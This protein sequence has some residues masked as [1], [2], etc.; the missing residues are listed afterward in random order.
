MKSGNDTGFTAVGNSDFQLGDNVTNKTHLGHFTFYF[1]PVVHEPNHIMIARDVIFQGYYGGAGTKWFGSANNRHSHS[2][3]GGWENILASVQNAQRTRPSLL[4]ALAFHHESKN[5]YICDPMS[6]TG[7]FHS[8][9]ILNDLVDD[10]DGYHY[11]SA[12][13][14]SKMLGKEF[15]SLDD[16][17]ANA[18]GGVFHNTSAS[19]VCYQGLQCKRDGQGKWEDYTENTG[20]LGRCESLDSSLVWSGQIATKTSVSYERASNSVSLFNKST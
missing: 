12:P 8:Q 3:D 11:A 4:S 18:S 6:I 13:Y 7:K 2:E 19:G 14:Y 9:S 10:P 20:H 15:D 5:E 17:T 16:T 1:E